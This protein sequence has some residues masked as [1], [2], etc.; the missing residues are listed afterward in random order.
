MALRGMWASMWS[1]RD[2]RMGRMRVPR[3]FRAQVE[4]VVGEP[5]SGADVTAELLEAKVRG[6][7]GDAA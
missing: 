1:H 7:R 2:N 6:L 4:V 5:L 3:R